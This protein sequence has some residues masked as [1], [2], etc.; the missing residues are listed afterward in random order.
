MTQR[1][2][3]DSSTKTGML[4]LVDLAGSE[5]VK[6]THATGQVRPVSPLDACLRGLRM[7]EAPCALFLFLQKRWLD[8]G[9]RCIARTPGSSLASLQFSCI[10]NRNQN[11][12]DEPPPPPVRCVRGYLTQRHSESKEQGSRR[13]QGQAFSPLL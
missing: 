10:L 13:G 5:M 1:D 4:Y 3:N 2:V 11:I 8:L 7:F 12:N 9:P 6:K